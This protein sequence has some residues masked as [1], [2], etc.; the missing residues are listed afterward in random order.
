M[1]I[2]FNQVRQFN[3]SLYEVARG[4]LRSRE[5]LTKKKGTQSR[6]QTAQRG[7]RTTHRSQ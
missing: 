7:E 5:R 6:N 2:L 4:V 1:S 3:S